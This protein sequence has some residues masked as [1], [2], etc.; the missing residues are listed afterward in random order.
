M[1]TL[2]K[3]LCI[4]VM[5]SV[6]VMIIPVSSLAIEPVSGSIIANAFAQAITGY[7]AAQGVSMMFDVSDTSQIGE[8]I[9][10]LWKQYKS[11]FNESDNYLDLAATLYP[12]LFQKITTAGKAYLGIRLTAQYVSE[13][14]GFWNW[15]LSGPAEMTK[16]DNQ[17]YKWTIDQEGQVEPINIANPSYI[18]IN[19]IPVYQGS[20][21]FN[22]TSGN[23]KTLFSGN[24][25]YVAYY[26]TNNNV[27]TVYPFDSNQFTYTVST[28]SL[29]NNQLINST[30]TSSDSSASGWYYGRYQTGADSSSDYQFYGDTNAPPLW[31]LIGSYDPLTSIV[32]DSA[33]IDIAPYIGDTTP[34]DVYIPDN[35]D[36]N[37]VP[38]PADIPLDIPWDDSLFGDGTGTL[39]DAQVINAVSSLDSTIEQL[40]SLLLAGDNAITANP[41]DTFN[42]ILP[43]GELPSFNFNLAGIWYYVRNWVAS[44]GSFITA[45]FTAWS[46]LPS[47]ISLPVYATAV[48]VIVLGVYK[49]FFM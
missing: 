28:Y 24:C 45:M 29:S 41:T 42:S 15:I 1:T 33:K 38:L 43:F 40:N 18:E 5:A 34:Q 27:L 16:V 3:I 9:H 14:D 10:E 7:G 26:Q 47:I 25:Y 36:V 48:I 19:G 4:C 44:L 49:R 12:S 22:N 32:Y 37:Y 23:V 39:S 35:E 20:Y 13:L 8:S 11:S 30:T 46:A 2:R 21:I 31:N 6:L 17:Y